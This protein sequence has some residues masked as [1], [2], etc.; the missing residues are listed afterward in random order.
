MR[1]LD[2]H[3]SQLHEKDGAPIETRRFCS[4]EDKEVPFEVIGRGYDLDNG[5]QVILTDEELATAAPRKT[6]TIDIEAFVDLADIDPIY[7]D[8]PYF[9]LPAGETEGT[10]RAY[11]LLLEVM[12][13]TD[14]AALGRFVHAHEGVPRDRSASATTCSR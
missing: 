13:R 4:E 5:D 1:D 6:R 2:L 11:Q 12:Q 9:L 14:R 3:F 8:H 7:F 10:V